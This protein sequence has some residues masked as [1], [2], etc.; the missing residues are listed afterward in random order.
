MILGVLLWLVEF[1]LHSNLLIRDLKHLW[2]PV[3]LIGALRPQHGFTMREHN[4]VL[5]RSVHPCSRP[6]WS[7]AFAAQSSLHYG[8]FSGHSCHT[9]MEAHSAVVLVQGPNGACP[10]PSFC[11]LAVGLGCSGWS[12][13]ERGPVRF[14]NSGMYVRGRAPHAM[15]ASHVATVPFPLLT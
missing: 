6:P 10:A 7:P 4:P 2:Q 15:R 5:T 9:A 11:P 8:S 13:F 1:A 3:V 12:P 14:S